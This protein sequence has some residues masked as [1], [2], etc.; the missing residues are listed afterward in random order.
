MTAVR[1]GYKIITIY[2]VY[3]WEKTTTYNPNSREG[4]LFAQYI[5]TFL[6]YKQ[7]AS[8]PPEW[9]KTKEDM[10]LYRQQYFEREGVVL[11]Q[12]H[13]V[14]NPGLRALAKLCLNSFWG[15]FGQRLN[16]KQTSFFH[17]DEVNEFFQIFCDPTKQ[18][19]NFHILTDDIIQTEWTYKTEFQ[20]E[21]NKTN[22]Y[23]ATFTTCWARLKLYSVL[24]QLDRRV[25]YYDT[26]S[27]IYISRPGEVD[28]PLGDYLGELTNELDAGEYIERFVSL[29]PKN[30]GYRTNTNKETCKVR[31][32]TLNYTN[33]QLIHLDA[34][35][36]LLT[37]KK[38]QSSIT[39]TNPHK[40][41]RDK[42]KRK[43]YNREESKSYQMVYTKRRILD[44]YDT[45]PY[46]F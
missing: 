3:H 23:V 33:S 13:I 32:F 26:D 14:K 30:Y 1:L 21:D 6:K 40:I 36:T 29:G 31:G 44:N 16:M 7:E 5:N 34:M 38:S 9:I 20:P 35:E 43:L 28:P 10:T 8:G 27:I 24:E 39:V 37:K 18:P 41:C 11:D 12:T 4:G 17:E 15:K 25:L 2:E 45:V 19:H 46:G 22:I 42:R